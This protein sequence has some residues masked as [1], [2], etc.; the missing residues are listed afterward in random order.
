MSADQRLQQALRE[1]TELQRLARPILEALENCEQRIED[2][3][4]E[5]EHRR[6]IRKC[7]DVRVCALSELI[8]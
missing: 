7:V 2:A 6:P 4:A 8:S 1:R 3:R 5:T